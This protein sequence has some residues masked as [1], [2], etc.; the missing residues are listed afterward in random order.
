MVFLLSTSKMQTI[1]WVSCWP[2]NQWLLAGSAHL[3]ALQRL[4]ATPWGN[5]LA[6]TALH[7]PAFAILCLSRWVGC[8]LQPKRDGHPPEPSLKERDGNLRVGFG[9]KSGFGFPT[10]PNADENS[11]SSSDRLPVLVFLAVEKRAMGLA[12]SHENLGA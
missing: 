11:T 6:G 8:G 10:L 2:L 4:L 12:M 9:G 5:F 1:V 3:C 7:V